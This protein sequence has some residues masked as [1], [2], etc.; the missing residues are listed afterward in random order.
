MSATSPDAA[1]LAM[2]A[3]FL[4][5]AYLTY[6]CWSPPNPNPAGPAVSLPKDTVGPGAGHIQVRRLVS[7]SLWIWHI[8]VTVF[9]HSPPA[10]FCPNPGNLASSLFTWSP[11]TAAVLMII[12]TAAPIRLLAFRELQENFTFRLAKPKRLVKTGPYAYVQHPSYPTNWLILAANI[13]LLLR[14]DGV[15]SCVLPGRVVRWGMGSGGFGVW[16]VLLT[17]LAVFGLISIW[18]R[19]QDEEAMLREEFGREWEEYHRRTKRFVPG[20]F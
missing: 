13:A 9:Y 3:S 20:V 15:L 18:V 4:L 5:A 8:L 16:P 10:M 1:S 2:A 14:L 19:V 6:R 7:L 12:V 17:V 11:Y